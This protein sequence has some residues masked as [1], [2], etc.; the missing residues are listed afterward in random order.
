MELSSAD[1][2]KLR[3]LEE[4]AGILKAAP[5]VRF[6]RG[7]GFVLLCLHWAGLPALLIGLALET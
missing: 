2:E 1:D 7:R 6:L 3:L 5:R 4:A